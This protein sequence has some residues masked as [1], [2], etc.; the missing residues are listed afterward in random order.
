MCYQFKYDS[1]HRKYQG[2]VA[3]DDSTHHMVVD[4]KRIKVF[5]EPDPQNIPWGDYGADIIV[6]ATG[7]FQTEEKARAHFKGGAK[8]VVMCAPPKDDTPMF[9]V[10]VNEKEYKPSQHIISNA[11]CTTNCLAPMAKIIHDRFGIE[12]GLMT[13]V[14]AATASQ[15]TVDGTSSKDW[16]GGRGAVGLNVIPSTTGAAKA[17]GKVIPSLK[18]KLTGMAMRIP[19][20]NVSVVDLTCLLQKKVAYAELCAAMKEASENELN[21]IMGYTEDAVVS[22]D[23]MSDPLSCIFD[24]K[25]GMALDENFVK[26]IGWYDNEYGYSCRV[27]DLVKHVGETSNLVK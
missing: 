9:V 4:G 23:F 11:S 20:P 15:P 14:H 19:T 6:E 21:G 26:V 16:R 10:G 17:V 1:T 2:T 27:L 24:A 3:F 18:G 25:A 8:K 12:K 13:T 7:Q 22:S 5:M